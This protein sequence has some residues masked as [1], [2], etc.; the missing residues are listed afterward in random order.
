MSIL[1]A[2]ICLLVT[3]A[4]GKLHGASCPDL[5]GVANFNATKF[6]GLWY[7]QQRY[8][9]ILEKNGKCVFTK[10]SLNDDKSIGI[11]TTYLNGESNEWTILEG[12]AISDS[13]TGE[14][15]FTVEFKEPAL[16]APFWILDIDYDQFFVPYSC[17]VQD[18]EVIVAVICL[19][20]TAA[21]GKLHGASCPDMKGVANF[22]ATK[23][24]GLWYEQKR[25]PTIL[26][27]NGKCAFIQLSLNEDTSIGL[28]TTYL[29]GETNEWTIVEAVAVPDSTTGEAKFTLTFKEPALTAP[30]W[31]LG[32]DYNQFFV[33]YSCLVV[34]GE[35]IENLYIYTKSLNPSNHV[36][37]A[38]LKVIN[39]NNLDTTKLLDTDQ[40]C[41][42]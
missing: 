24:V 22:D 25:Y 27:I 21:H 11:N 17:L 36:I 40:T 39:H 9:T 4:H 13:A 26:E 6:V 41:V 12:V 28:N 5:K 29:N 20:V 2:V 34:D 7:E 1:L 33:P 38:A 37:N 16:T 42:Y 35:V 23:I 31:I 14:A 8:P 15:K 32:I 19:L 3:A 10:Y 30:F 18:G